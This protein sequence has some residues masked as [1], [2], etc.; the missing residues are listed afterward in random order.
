MRRA[1][2]L[3]E[4]M[5]DWR[6]MTSRA[7]YKETAPRWFRISPRNFTGR[8]L[9]S[10]LGHEG[11]YFDELLATDACKELVSGPNERGTPDREWTA[12]NLRDIPEYTLLIVCGR[13]AQ[14]TY[15]RRQIGCRIIEVPHPAARMWTREALDLVRDQVQKGETSVRVEIY[16]DMVTLIPL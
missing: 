1:V 14:A 4:V 13:I 3:L 16:K 10:W 7:G 12:N 6:S 15:D 8:R 9:Y 2:A 5:W 11:E